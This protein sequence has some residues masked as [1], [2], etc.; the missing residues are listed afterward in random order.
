M[1]HRLAGA[2]L[3]GY[4]FLHM[5]VL[6]SLRDP[7]RFAAL[8]ALMKHPLVKAGELGLLA[9][10]LLHGLNGLRVTLL[11]LGLPTRTQKPL[12]YGGMALGAFVLVAGA[13][14]LFGG[15]A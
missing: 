15:Q 5:H 4:L 1:L 6:A 9:L 13:F 10:V 14:V 8:M 3:T 11:E 2:A 7:E 12:F